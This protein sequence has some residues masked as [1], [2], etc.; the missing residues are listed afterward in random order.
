MNRLA[1]VF[2]ESYNFSVYKK[3]L[4][5]Y[6]GKSAKHQMNAHLAQFVLEEDGEDTL[7]IIYYAGHGVKDKETGLLRLVG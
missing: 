6:K 2:E 1:T 7:L 3:H 4:H 5:A